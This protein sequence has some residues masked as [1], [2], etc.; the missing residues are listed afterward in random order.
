MPRFGRVVLGGTF[1]RLH[2]GHEALLSTALRAGRSVAVGLTTERFLAR[3]PKPDGPRIQ[4]YGTRRRALRRWLSDRSPT[5]R[6]TVV[7]LEDTF[8]GSVGE[9]V[10]ALV[11]SADTVAGGR[12]VNAER[13]RLG[14]KAIPVLVVPLV[15]A[16]DLRPVSSRRIR[17][18]EITASGRRRSAIDIGLAVEAEEDRAPAARAILATFP[19]GRIATT[20]FPSG[21]SRPSERLRSAGT[22]A[23]EHGELGVAV[24]RAIRGRAPVVV[25]SSALDL[26]PETLPH[27]SPRAF[28]NALASFLGRS[29]PAKPFS[30]G[31]G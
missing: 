26:A 24:G 23:A 21:L 19:R 27:G 20:P 8:G 11:V 15:L 22:S 4:S 31:R 6:W 18:G 25:R 2:A 14:R 13:R 12:A 16:E 7:P 1:D 29:D 10:D 9:E 5:T 3:H 30:L 28:S 17:S